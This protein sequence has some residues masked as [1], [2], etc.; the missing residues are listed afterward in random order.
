[1]ENRKTVSMPGLPSGEARAKT[2]YIRDGFE[3]LT[4]ELVSRGWTA[5]DGLNETP[6]L[7]MTKKITEACNAKLKNGQMTNHFQG[8]FALSSKTGLSGTEKKFW[9]W[10]EE[11]AK[12]VPLTFGF[13]PG[14]SEGAFE[15]F[16]D[17]FRLYE[18]SS[19]GIRAL[20]AG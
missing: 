1:M 5:V 19:S 17:V 10:G 4:R 6:R 8:I 7:Y 20:R 13:G 2:F 11:S 15:R 16:S 14:G 12:F 18:V 3:V 9:W